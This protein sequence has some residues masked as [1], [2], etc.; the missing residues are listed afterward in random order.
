M[1]GRYVVD[2]G[3]VAFPMENNNKDKKNTY[4]IFPPEGW[5]NQFKNAAATAYIILS[6]WVDC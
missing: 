5:E 2:D 6:Y 4:L 1:L 3:N